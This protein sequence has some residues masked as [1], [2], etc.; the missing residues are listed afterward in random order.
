LEKENA[1]RLWSSRRCTKTRNRLNL[2]WA[3]LYGHS[4]LLSSR[5]APAV[6]DP[7]PR[8]SAPKA[9]KMPS[10]QYG[11]GLSNREAEA[12]RV[13]LMPIYREERSCSPRQPWRLGG[14]ASKAQWVHCG[15]RSPPQSSGYPNNRCTEDSPGPPRDPSAGWMRRGSVAAGSPRGL[16]DCHRA[17]AAFS[18]IVGTVLGH[19]H[20]AVHRALH[21][22][23]ESPPVEL[24][25]VLDTAGR[26]GV[27]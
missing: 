25:T 20:S 16:P 26:G 24:R 13:H 22:G 3:G 15:P 9:S 23:S 19:D 6:M 4:P 8:I 14:N 2:P 18:W 5:I 17:E 1:A 21:V 11:Q 7:N 10:W 12:T 27:A